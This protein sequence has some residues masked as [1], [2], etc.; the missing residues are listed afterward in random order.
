[1]GV[2]NCVNGCWSPEMLMLLSVDGMTNQGREFCLW[3]GF[4]CCIISI[5]DVDSLLL[6]I[7]NISLNLLHFIQPSIILRN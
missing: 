4:F 3:E 2:E 5:K 6:I 7:Q 1:M